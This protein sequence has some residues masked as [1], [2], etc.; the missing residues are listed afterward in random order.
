M[1]KEQEPKWRKWATHYEPLPEE[2]Q[3]ETA[4]MMAECLPN[5]L[6]AHE[7]EHDLA[8]RTQENGE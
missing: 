2:V 4:A 1:A 6:E 8:A 3:R 5:I 7:R